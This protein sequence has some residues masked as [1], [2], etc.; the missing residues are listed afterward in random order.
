MIK[1]GGRSGN[2]LRILGRC[3]VSRTLIL[4]SSKPWGI[5]IDAAL[6]ANSEALPQAQ[7]LHHI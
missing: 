4:G 7:R 6:K 2:F 3:K 1:D 5:K